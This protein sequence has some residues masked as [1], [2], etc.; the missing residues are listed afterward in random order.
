[1]FKIFSFCKKIKPK[2]IVLS[3]YLNNGEELIFSH[4]I[5]QSNMDIFLKVNTVKMA[6]ILFDINQLTYD[7][8]NQRY[9][10]NISV[11][12]AQQNTVSFYTKHLDDFKYLKSYP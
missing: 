1:M 7:Y 10:M 3:I 12:W 5:L 4:E 2:T 6:T 11:V 8:I 9:E